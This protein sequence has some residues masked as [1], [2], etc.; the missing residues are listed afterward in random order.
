MNFFW[1]WHRNGPAKHIVAVDALEAAH[2]YLRT[3][4]FSVNAF[5]VPS[6][7]VTEFG[8]TVDVQAVAS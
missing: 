1:V 7:A 8:G 5:V 3:Y 4:G 6:D 2:V